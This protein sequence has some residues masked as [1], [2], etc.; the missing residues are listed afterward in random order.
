MFAQAEA[1]PIVAWLTW[2][3][4]I[5]VA[6]CGLVLVVRNARQKGRREAITEADRA[7]NEIQTLRA[8]R[9]KD[10]RLIYQL[11]ESLATHGI[12]PP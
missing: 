12:E 1:L 8:E 11:R 7:Y 6:G 5:V 2:C 9:V 3:G 10:S 4:A